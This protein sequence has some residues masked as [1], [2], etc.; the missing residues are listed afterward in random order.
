MVLCFGALRLCLGFGICLFLVLGLLGLVC[1]CCLVV[2][3]FGVFGFDALFV[4]L[5]WFWWFGCLLVC[6]VI[7]CLG[8]LTDCGFCF[9]VDCVWLLD[10]V[11]WVCLNAGVC[12]A[13]D[14]FVMSFW[15]ILVF[16]VC[17]WFVLLFGW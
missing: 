11:C 5:F 8:L 13:V 3:F 9:I 10:L 12:L 6:V 4:G 14:L 16:L 2:G 7:Y 1:F 17:D 15:L